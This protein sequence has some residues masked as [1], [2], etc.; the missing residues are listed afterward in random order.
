M[1]AAAGFWSWRWLLALHRNHVRAG[2]IRWTTPRATIRSRC[3][4][5]VCARLWR[6]ATRGLCASSPTRRKWWLDG[7]RTTKAGESSWLS[8]VLTIATT[9]D[10][11]P[12]FPAC[13]RLALCGQH[14]TLYLSPYQVWRFPG[15]LERAAHLVIA[16]DKAILRADPSLDSASVATLSFDIVRRMGDPVKGAGLGEWVPVCTLDGKRGFVMSRDLVSPVAPRAQFGFQAGRWLL[17]ALE[18]D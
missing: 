11:G 17:I 2:S 15:N 8:G 7:R 1:A 3:M 13:W 4:Y 9:G 12:R 18:D 16:R 6:L 5:G 14:P 10:S